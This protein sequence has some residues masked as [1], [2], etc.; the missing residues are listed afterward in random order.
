M[1]FKD[2]S[3]EEQ[4][5]I[6]DFA[7]RSCKNKDANS[8]FA[9]LKKDNSLS[10]ES[11]GPCHAGLQIYDE[12][13]KNVK[14]ILSSIQRPLYKKEEWMPFLNWL[15]N[16]SVYSQI[17]ILN[18]PEEV[19]KYGLVIDPNHNS[20]LIFSAIFA[21]RFFTESHS[22]EVS[23][24]F[25][26]YLI[27]KNAGATEEE[28]LILAH[29][30]YKKGEK[31]IF[32]ELSSGHAMFSSGKTF[33]YIYNWLNK[34]PKTNLK[35]DFYSENG[36]FYGVCAMW[37]PTVNYHDNENGIRQVFHNLLKEEKVKNSN[38]FYKEPVDQVSLNKEDIS[39]FLTNLRKTFK[40]KEKEYA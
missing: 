2:L 31:L 23:E 11:R 39:V 4:K 21:S 40:S 1:F 29:C 30:F 37:G 13:A 25:R 7:E 15:L 20:N 19:F 16:K 35:R 34:T 26:L 6:A 32:S 8:Y 9:V 5:Q 28:A 18:D 17:F 27:F 12:S 10:K 36:T 3:K 14:Y 24:R 22:P 33:D 38:I